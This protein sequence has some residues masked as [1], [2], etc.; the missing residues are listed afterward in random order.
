MP[1]PWNFTNEFAAPNGN[2]YLRY[3]SLSEFGQGSPLTGECFWVGPDGLMVQL[4]GRYGG[5]PVWN[6]TGQRAALPRWQPSVLGGMRQHLA[7]LDTQLRKLAV[8]QQ[9]FRVLHLQEF[10]HLLVTGLDSPLYNTNSLLFNLET[11]AIK[12][13]FEL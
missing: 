5:P 11:A 1:D 4:F 2:Q 13:V 12:R 6:A 7:V 3:D 10:I 9:S 8:F